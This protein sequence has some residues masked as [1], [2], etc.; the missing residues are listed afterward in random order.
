MSEHEPGAVYTALYQSSVKAVIL[1]EA[2][3]APPGTFPGDFLYCVA[4]AVP[5]FADWCDVRGF[6]HL[7][8]AQNDYEARIPNRRK[9]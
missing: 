3:K 5:P 9:A 4:D 8:D 7:E 6:A 1:A 2:S